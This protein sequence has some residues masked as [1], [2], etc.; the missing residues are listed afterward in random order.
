MNV[1]VKAEI[2]FCVRLLDF[3]LAFYARDTRKENIVNVAKKRNNGMSDLFEEHTVCVCE[4]CAG[5][6]AALFNRRL[7][8]YLFYLKSLKQ[9]QRSA[10]YISFPFS[11]ASLPVIR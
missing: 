3:P 4:V 2:C 8:L 10:C 1:L 11:I 6:R 5:G 7:L 9:N